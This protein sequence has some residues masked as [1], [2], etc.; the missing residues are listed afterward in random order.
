MMSEA[1]FG[2]DYKFAPGFGIG[3]AYYFNH[4]DLDRNGRAWDGGVEYSFNGPQVYAA[5]AF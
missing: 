2:G 1:R 5:F 3:A 4:T